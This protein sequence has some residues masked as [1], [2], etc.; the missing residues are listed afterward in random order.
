MRPAA[1]FGFNNLEAEKQ[2]LIHQAAFAKKST[3]SAG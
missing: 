1:S 2:L 3:Q